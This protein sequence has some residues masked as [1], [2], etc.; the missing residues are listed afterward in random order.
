MATR[1]FSSSFLFLN[2]LQS[3]IQRSLSKLKNLKMISLSAQ[4]RDTAAK[5]RLALN[6][7]SPRSTT[8]FC[9]VSLWLLCTVMAHTRRTG[10]CNRE[11]IPVLPSQVHC[12]G[13]IGITFMFLKVVMVEP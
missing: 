8:A 5:K 12:I 2:L 9:N 13:A 6:S 11:H 3:L 7:L 1:H 4:T 10:T